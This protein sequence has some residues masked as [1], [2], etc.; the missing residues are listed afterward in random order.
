MYCASCAFTSSHV[1][2]EACCQSRSKRPWTGELPHLYGNNS[3][4]VSSCKLCNFPI[5]WKES[6]AYPTSLTWSVCKNMFFLH[7]L[8]R[9]SLRNFRKEGMYGSLFDESGPTNTNRL[10]KNAA[11]HLVCVKVLYKWVKLA[12]GTDSFLHQITKP[13]HLAPDL[14]PGR[15]DKIMMSV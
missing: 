9:G 15:T 1:G 12:S 7:G 3:H 14:T 13:A 5:N 2:V 11:T 10:R 4:M 6:L 8:R